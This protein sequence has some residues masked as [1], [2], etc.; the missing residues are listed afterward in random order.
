[1]INLQKVALG[2][3]EMVLP[4]GRDQALWQKWCLVWGGGLR[5]RDYTHL[6]VGRLISRS[7]ERAVRI[8]AF[9]NVGPM[10]CCHQDQGG[11]LG[12]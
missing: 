6:G 5:V 10:C 12:I 2:I 9:R 7:F 4:T 3:E 8:N 1:M 11:I